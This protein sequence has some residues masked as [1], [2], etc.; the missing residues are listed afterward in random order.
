MMSLKRFSQTLVF[1]ALFVL[2]T[3]N[4]YANDPSFNISNQ[5][6]YSISDYGITTVK[7]RTSITNKTDYIYTPTYTIH[8]GLKDVSNI[9]V[10]NSDGGIPFKVDNTKEGSTIE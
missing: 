10:Y 6:T 2:C 8:T 9:K 5:S 3:S 7:Q 1:F 4:V